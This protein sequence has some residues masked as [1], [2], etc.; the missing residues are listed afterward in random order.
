MRSQLLR[1]RF[2]A[3]LSFGWMMADDE[4]G[5]VRAFRS[6]LRQRRWRYVL[7]VPANTLIRDLADPPASGR[8]R[9][10]WRRVDAWVAAQPVSRWRR[11][12]AGD[13][14]NGL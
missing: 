11:I 5:R 8:P 2:G 3:A 9:P 4:F 1:R 13:G 10:P 7:D 12:R 14:T 6:A